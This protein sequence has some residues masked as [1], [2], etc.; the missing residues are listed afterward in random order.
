MRP[1]LLLLLL[2]LAIV[3]TG[4]CNWVLQETQVDKSMLSNNLDSIGF[5]VAVAV[6]ALSLWSLRSLVESEPDPFFLN[7]TF[8]AFA[9]QSIRTGEA[10]GNKAA[11]GSL[12]L[13]LLVA[14]L[15]LFLQVVIMRAFVRVT[16]DHYK[17]QLEKARREGCPDGEIDRWARLL[18]KI[19]GTDFSPGSYSWLT[20]IFKGEPREKS[21]RQALSILPDTQFDKRSEWLT[22]EGLTISASDRSRLW[23][24]YVLI[25]VGSWMVF[26]VALFVSR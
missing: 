13:L 25:A 6:I 14:V 3:L 5:A 12:F 19:S 1:Q 10:V 2:L 9:G 21:K 4:A 15:F 8:F 22:V 7:I 17:D 24:F 20:P 11:T 26:V 18:V 16:I 23:Q